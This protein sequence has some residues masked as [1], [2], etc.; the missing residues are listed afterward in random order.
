MYASITDKSF[1][2]LEE[3]NLLPANSSVGECFVFYLYIYDALFFLH[4]RVHIVTH[5]LLSTLTWVL[6]I[7]NV[8]SWSLFFLGSPFDMRGKRFLEVRL[9]PV[10]KKTS[11]DG[12]STLASGAGAGGAN[13]PD[14]GS[15]THS[16][17]RHSGSMWGINTKRLFGSSSSSS[18]S[19][20]HTNTS[21]QNSPASPVP[22]AQ[23][24]A[25]VVASNDPILQ[26]VTS[27]TKV[28]FVQ[29]NKYLYFVSG[30]K[31]NSRSGFKVLIAAPLLYTGTL[32]LSHLFHL[33]FSLL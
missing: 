17:A 8:F 11:V 14:N 26:L 19:H 3:K 20:A 2:C 1:L 28:L 32:P 5:Q 23:N 29:D 30:E 25:T 22:G 13:T 27:K 10:Q 4:W 12:V 9:I 24:V 16:P 31:V 6:S 21:H 18:S 7:L 33:I 15:R